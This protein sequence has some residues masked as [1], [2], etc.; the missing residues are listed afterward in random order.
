M[1]TCTLPGAI[2]TSFDSTHGGFKLL[3]SHSAFCV[4]LCLKSGYF[5]CPC[6]QKSKISH[7]SAVYFWQPSAANQV[8]TMTNQQRLI[9]PNLLHPQKNPSSNQFAFTF[10]NLWSHHCEG[11]EKNSC[12]SFSTILLWLSA[13]NH[14]NW[15][16]TNIQALT[17]VGY[18]E[19]AWCFNQ[20]LKCGW[21]KS[22]I[23]YPGYW[24]SFSWPLKDGA[25]QLL[26]GFCAS[27]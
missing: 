3:L 25:L 6:D 27:L 15:W 11:S 18:N 5:A 20:G 23:P 8:I 26:W 9:A 2:A 21:N 1:L 4:L 7:S 16:K 19:K 17:A 10:S 14:R 13:S 24:L 12:Q 22:D